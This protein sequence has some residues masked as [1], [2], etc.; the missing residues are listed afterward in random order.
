MRGGNI[1]SLPTRRDLHAVSAPV[2]CVVG[3]RRDQGRGDKLIANFS[4]RR[5]SDGDPNA[6]PRAKGAATS[7]EAKAADSDADGGRRVV[8]DMGPTQRAMPAAG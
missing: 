4:R 5:L 3:R 8:E 6:Q 7:R 1:H 2:G